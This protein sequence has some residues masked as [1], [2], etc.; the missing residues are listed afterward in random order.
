[1]FKTDCFLFL[2][3]LWKRKPNAKTK[4]ET[5]VRLTPSAIANFLVLVL[6]EFI[7]KQMSILIEVYMTSNTRMIAS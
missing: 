1:M 6:P 2:F 3:V 7:I 5:N 4:I